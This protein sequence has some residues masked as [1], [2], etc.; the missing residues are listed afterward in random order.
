[1]LRLTTIFL[2]CF[3]GFHFSNAQEIKPDFRL[4]AIGKWLERHDGAPANW[5]GKKF[6]HKELREPINVV[7][8]DPFAKSKEEAINKLMAECKKHGY[9]DKIGHSSG[10]CAELD[11]TR[12]SQLPGEH[13]RALANK[14]FI[15]TNNHG[16]I[17]GPEFFDGKY[18]FVGAFSREAFQF[19]TKA[20]HAYRSF[21]IARNDFCQKLS[22]GETYKI[23]GQY[24]LGNDIN[25]N[26]V[27]TG[28]HDGRAILLFANR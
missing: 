28:D 8:V 1:M 2:L 15:R 27:T 20:H 26:E 12:L 24:N 9:K 4:P 16:R 18:I 17:L 6:Q 13:K 23:V 7:I 22:K 3:L 11:S 21:L 25:T 14:G 5:L 19:F 10:Y